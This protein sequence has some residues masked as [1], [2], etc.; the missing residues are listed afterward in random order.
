VSV[1]T[2]ALAA[3][4]AGS[5]FSVVDTLILRSLPYPDANRL[6]MIRTGLQEQTDFPA[7]NAE[8]LDYRNDSKTAQAVG[9]WGSDTATAQIGNGDPEVVNFAW[10]TPSVQPILGL[11]TAVGR[12]FVEV[13]GTPD[14]PEV[15]L[16]SYGYWMSHF[17]GDPNVV[18]GRA[19]Q[20]GG[21][22]YR[23]VGVVAE[24]FSLPGA[25]P[26]I[27]R[28]I[29]LP[30]TSGQL[31]SRS[32]HYLNVVARLREGVTL[33]EASAEADRLVTRWEREFRGEHVL[34]PESHPMKI[35][36]LAEWV[37]GGA[38]RSVRLIVWAAALVVLL[39]CANLSTLMLARAETRKVDLGMRRALGARFGAQVRNVMLE[40]VAIALIGGA[41]G[42]A[43]SAGI[44]KWI[45]TQS[46]GSMQVGASHLDASGVDLR[47]A[48][49]T[50]ALAA[51]SGIAFGVLPAI[52]AKRVD[53][54][55]LLSRTGGRSGTGSRRLRRSFNAMVFV[56]LAL[57]AVLLNGTVMLINGFTHAARIDPGFAPEDRLAVALRLSS[58]EYPDG[59]PVIRFYDRL[60]DAIGTIPG[61]ESVAAAR[62]MPL[63]RPLGT[64]AF[65]HEGQVWHDG[66]PASQVDFQMVSPGYDRT[67]G[68][69]VLA[70]REFDER[71]RAESPRVAM[72]NRA[73]AVAYFGSVHAALGKRIVPLFMGGPD[74][75]PFT[76]VGISENVR[77]L[78][79]I[80]DVRPE[81]ELPIAQA[82]GW[83][84]GVLRRGELVVHV[85]P[86]TEASVLKGIRAT[87]AKLAPGVPIT[88]P[89]TMSEALRESTA[90][91]RFLTELTSGFGIVALLIAGV[92][93]LGIAWFS[94]NTRWR[95]LGVRMAL[96]QTGASVT[97]MVL[98][99]GLRLGLGG[100]LIGIAATAGIAR[101]VHAAI[102]VPGIVDPLL[103]G[104]STLV[105]IAFAGLA[106]LGPALQAGRLDPATILGAE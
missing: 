2:I 14:G 78:G 58:S 37:L 55:R 84:F 66:D 36:G 82:Q 8:Y 16:L 34:T 94:V 21:T 12:P 88:D 95:E 101:V 29:R 67:M 77:H 17:G 96:G 18:D 74:A 53:L 15:V 41:L 62:A 24:G 106:C 83:V 63:R 3:G 19:L 54:T 97:R 103:L 51:A 38:W 64:E 73:A 27:Y 56:Q 48:L 71:D 89:G 40:S 35:R 61:V 44:L 104:L 46:V 32:S 86:G 45:G 30:E 81:I 76:I 6:V 80:G 69:T 100:A 47:L 60:L 7:S 65:I 33:R 92:G 91:Q 43:L 9:A 102:P 28:P 26:S 23:I 31:R 50:V 42:L 20:L 90:Y 59:E 85:R 4:V 1:V 13:D 39:A 98:R 70:G 52:A 72:L 87:L 5:V 57:A 49:F 10:I 68:I 75:D 93:A 25:S 11:S 22:P 79:L 105:L 99:Q